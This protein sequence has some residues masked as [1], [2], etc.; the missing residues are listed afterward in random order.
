M[1][2]LANRDDLNPD[3]VSMALARAALTG[4]SPRDCYEAIAVPPASEDTAR[5]ALRTLAGRWHDAE[6]D[7]FLDLSDGGDGTMVDSWDYRYRLGTDGI[8]YGAGA[9]QGA[10]WTMRDG[11]LDLGE[12]FSDWLD[13]RF[14]RMPADAPTSAAPTGE[15]HCP[16]LKVRAQVD[17]ASDGA[18]VV[19]IGSA[20]PRRLTPA[21]GA[22]AGG[23]VTVRPDG[24]GLLVSA[25]RM[26]RL[27]FDRA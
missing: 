25:N 8:W 15:F 21:G 20:K 17:P 14:R 12:Q 5:A 16:E 1:T 2:V 22:W 11:V 18:I 24:S 27:R 9:A 4:R 3:H 7:S 23:G 10:M 6:P 26:R 13:G 19:T